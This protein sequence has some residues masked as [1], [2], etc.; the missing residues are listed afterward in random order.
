MTAGHTVIAAP[1]LSIRRIAEAPIPERPYQAVLITSANGARALAGRSEL[2][3]LKSAPA[4][5]VGRSSAAA[6]SGAGFARIELAGGD[7]AA[8]ARRAVQLLRPDDGPL[9]YVSGAVTAGELALILAASG[10]EVDRVVAYVASPAVELPKRCTTALA[11]GRVDGVILFSPR[12]ARIWSTLVTAAGLA[13]AALRLV[14]YCLS[15][16]VAAMVRNTLGAGVTVEV[17]RRPDEAAL[18]EMLPTPG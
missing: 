17:A 5:V 8:L 12:T 1:L 11:A 15:Q 18:L 13:P 9:L 6:A 16:N 4:L 2:E 7:V 3:R 14:H 10:F